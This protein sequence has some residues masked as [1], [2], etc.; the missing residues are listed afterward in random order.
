M[1]LFLLLALSCPPTEIE[2]TLPQDGETFFE[3]YHPRKEEYETYEY[4]P[5]EELNPYPEEEENQAA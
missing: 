2:T 4:T 3:G 1:V 5:D